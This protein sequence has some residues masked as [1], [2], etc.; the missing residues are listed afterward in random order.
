MNPCPCGYLGDPAKECRCSSSQILT[1]QKRLSGPLLDRIDLVI[2]VSKVPHS[3]LLQNESMNTTQHLTAVKSIESATAIQRKRYNSSYKYNAS[4]TSQEISQHFSLPPDSKDLLLKAAD[5][6]QL[7][8]RS[9]FKVIKVA[10]TIADLADE[11]VI[12]PAHIAEAL[13]YRQA[14]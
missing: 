9:Y 1:Y 7:S 11:P 2:N 14:S 5:R 4:L 10:R 13:Q 8:A 12:L 3:A 6:L